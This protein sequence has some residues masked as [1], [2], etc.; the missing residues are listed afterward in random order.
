MN[1]SPEKRDA[2]RYLAEHLTTLLHGESETTRAKEASRIL[3]G[4]KFDAVDSRTLLEVFQDVP[5]TSLERTE[6]GS[7][8]PLLDLLVW[9]NVA[10]SKAAARRSVEGGGIYVNNERA[11]DV[12]MSVTPAMFVDGEA[13]V[14]RSGK[15]N[16]FLVKLSA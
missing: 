16:Y 7:G 8:L 4:E 13:L 3:F 10:N 1:S 15:K 9:C 2:Q 5:S 6:V 12:A 11:Q 14:I